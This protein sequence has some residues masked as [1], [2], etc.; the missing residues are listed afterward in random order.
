MENIRLSKITVSPLSSPLVIHKGN[1]HIYDTTISNS[2]LDGAFIS[3]G[4]ISINCT[5][6]A[7]S[8]TEGGTLTV[9]GGASVSKDLFVGKSLIVEGWNG[10]FQVGGITENR[11]FLDS[12]VNKQ[13]YISLD[14]VNKIFDMREDYLKF[15]ATTPSSASSVGSLIVAGGISIQSTANAQSFTSGGGLTLRGGIAVDKD[16]FFGSHINIKS[17]LTVGTSLVVANDI[18]TS[19][20]QTLSVTGGNGVFTNL[21]VGQVTCASILSTHARATN[22]STA[23]LIVSSSMTSANAFITNNLVTNFT[24]SNLLTLNANAN[25][26]TTANLNA[27]LGITTANLNS[28]N[29]YT[30][31]VFA[32][33]ATF[34]NGSF[35]AMT[36]SSF[37]SSDT[38]IG[39]LYVIN[40]SNTNMTSSSIIATNLV[41][42]NATCDSLITKV[43]ATMGKMY[44][45]ESITA[46]SNSNTL[47][48]IYTTGGNVGIGSVS[49]TAV[50]DVE[51]TL[52]VSNNVVFTGNVQSTNSSTSTFVLT[53]GG[54]SIN[55]SANS[56]SATQGG[57]MTINGGSAIAKDLYVGGQTILTNTTSNALTM[58]G[59]IFV[60]NTSNAISTSE[61]G[62]LTVLGGAGISKNVYIGGELT[63]N[64]TGVFND[65]FVMSTQHSI[66]SSVGAI[67]CSGGI[68]IDSTQDS[69]SI[70]QGGGLTIAGGCSISKDLY[71]GGEQFVYSATNY[72]GSNII[73]VYDS[74]EELS[75]SVSNESNDLVM[76]RHNDTTVEN[77]M[78]VSRSTGSILFSNTIP[79]TSL[80]SASIVISGGLSLNST[81]DAT[82]LDNGGGLTNAGG[83]SISKNLLVGGDAH[84]FSTTESSNVSTGAFVV[85][86]GVG[87]GGNINVL[88]NAV[89]QGD[90]TVNGT[91]LVV[92]SINTSLYD[93]ILQLNAGPSGSRDSGILI[94]RFQLD[95]DSGTGDIVN[96]TRFLSNVLGTQLGLT[97]TQIGF[98]AG[99]VLVD[100]Y[101]NGWWIKIASGFSSNQVRQ[102]VG[103]DSSSQIATV[104]SAWTSQ[105]PASG[106][107]IYLYNK[108]FV[109]IVYDEIRDEFVIG[110]TV[111]DPGATNVSF[112][113]VIPIKAYS[114][115]LTSTM[116]STSCSVGSLVMDGGLSISNTNEATSSSNG[117]SIT[118]KGGIGVGKSI[119]VGENLFIN[120]NT[121]QVPRG[122]TLSRPSSPEPGYMYFNLDTSDLEAYTGSVWTSLMSGGVLSDLDGDTRIQTESTLGADDDILTF[123]TNDNEIMRMS[124]A[125]NIGIGTTDPSSLLHVDGS[126]LLSSTTESVGVGTGGNLTVLG[127][128]SFSKD[129]YVG[130]VITSSSDIRL[131]ENITSFKGGD[132]KKVLDKI[133]SLRTVKFN[134]KHDPKDKKQI[135]FIAQ[136]FVEYFPELLRKPDENGYYTLDYPKITVILLECI[137]ELKE[138]IRKM[139]FK[140]IESLFDDT[141]F[142]TS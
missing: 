64:S 34:I 68:S 37:V 98:G 52:K 141:L 11:M 75:F 83:A 73:R 91:T 60:E 31:Q 85:D 137:K 112:T 8:S 59:G 122:D 128:A 28:T 101:Y 92:N 56:T 16:A 39:N 102:I 136:D 124:S 10:I 84:I 69:T 126:V 80:T 62:S 35:S 17:G 82:T 50:L 5:H 134:Y 90:L 20:L 29:T 132:N 33:S 100:D 113:D 58:S 88:G 70:T 114:M 43:D 15:E 67:I 138:D 3:N 25:N 41:S 140:L 108:S 9:G 89:F 66:S 57:A 42:Q 104:S 123:F 77:V 79:S 81:E 121:L 44:I 107:T 30:D 51:G 105:N 120:G 40:I 13:F 55:N 32:T 87:I 142:D 99:A 133:E 118:T 129:V 65:I 2:R 71:I 78:I 46:L 111:N 6:D 7:Q 86:G 53:R 74:F 63:C 130:G 49:P 26:I 117:G 21:S 48:S 119:Y 116:P 14:G 135:G 125:G 45:T 27:V 24:C 106:D 127:G 1:V 72:Y 38:S 76:R 139:K 93:N 95:N 18:S 110:S 94:Q 54:L 23:T 12:T 109:G 115:S 96:D 4:G 36:A 19:S 131:K 97:D 47:G 22:I 61:G 103:Y